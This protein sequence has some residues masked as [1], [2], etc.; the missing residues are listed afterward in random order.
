MG[1]FYGVVSI[2]AKTLQTTATSAIVCKVKLVLWH[3]NVCKMQ[4]FREKDESCCCTFCKATSKR[5][6]VRLSSSLNQS[7]GVAG[8]EQF[9]ICGHH[10]HFHAAVG[11]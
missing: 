4:R 7:E 2:D 6:A 11:R 10:H 1:L 8:D 5:T 3:L 9:F